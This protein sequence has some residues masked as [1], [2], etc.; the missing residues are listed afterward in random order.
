MNMVA[1]IALAALAAVLTTVAAAPAQ[2]AVTALATPRPSNTGQDNITYH[3]TNARLGWYNDET[4]LTAANVAS[5]AFH[6]IGSMKTQG[7]SYS[8]PL[9]VS[10]QTVTGG[11][12]HNL[13]IVTDSTDVVYA[14]DADS[15]ALVW[16][17][18]FTGAG[19][20]QQL[21]SD[22]GCDDTWPNIGINGTPVID[23]KRNLIYV[24]V[25]TF[26]S[27]TFFLRL[28]AIR[29]EDGVDGLTPTVIHAGTPGSPQIDPEYNFNRAG[30][31]EANNT[32][33]VALSTHCDFDGGAAH[34]W[35]LGYSATTLA[36]TG[37]LIDTT[38]NF[39][40][41]D[42]GTFLGSI[43]QGGFGIAAD[44]NNTI[45]F[46]TGNGANDGSTDFAQSVLAVPPD[47][48]PV[49]LN[50]FT[51]AT[52][53]SESEND[54]DLGSGGVMLLPIQ[55]TGPYRGLAIAGGKTG[56]KFLLDRFALG[57][58]HA[59]D[60]IAYETNTG[61]GQFGGPAYFVDSNNDQKILYGGTPNLNAYTLETVPYGLKLT[62]STNVGTLEN[63]NMGVTPVVSS[64]AQAAG[65]A[66]VWAI[67]T[68]PG[69][70]VGSAPIRLYAFNGANLGQTLFSATA[71]AWTGNGDTGGA[72]ITPLV[73]NGRVYLASDGMVTVFGIH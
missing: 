45:F 38:P 39:N 49:N 66:V 73:A 13:L 21:A 42:G 15:L 70:N 50:F 59:T 51:P 30:L 3:R 31:L 11:A 33:Y 71:G 41:S 57:G 37:N 62:S 47:L 7:K 5:S 28:H 27:G 52:W 48:K 68:P 18:S 60:K 55:T 26:E 54:Q 22:T 19:V 9:Y 46:A 14:Y 24:V 35:L 53:Q 8:Q 69:G 20:R 58:L 1:R 32:V 44:E 12:V 4:Q 34:G 10:N 72:L 56:E 43:W 36:L 25:P 61:G 23:R 67:S 2:S 65:T 29:L 6:L 63:R 17:R 40:E 64:N 16:K